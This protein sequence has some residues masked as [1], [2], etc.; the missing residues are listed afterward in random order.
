LVLILLASLKFEEE[1]GAGDKKLLQLSGR[2]ITGKIVPRGHRDG[3]SAKATAELYGPADR[4]AS[5]QL[6]SG[7]FSHFHSSSWSLLGM[8]ERSGIP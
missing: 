1:E 7:R 2:G 8:M 4:I 3:H 5:E 6:Y